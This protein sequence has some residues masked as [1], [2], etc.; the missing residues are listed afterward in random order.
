VADPHSPDRIAAVREGGGDPVHPD[1][2][3]DIDADE[4]ETEDDTQ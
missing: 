1:W 2:R 3:V 4:R